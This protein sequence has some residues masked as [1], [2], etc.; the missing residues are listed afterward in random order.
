MGG[1][2][3]DFEDEDDAAGPAGNAGGNFTFGR[4]SK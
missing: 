1:A 3:D 4:A 2:D